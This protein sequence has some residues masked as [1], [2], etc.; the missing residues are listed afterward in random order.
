[1]IFVGSVED[2]S[3][4]LDANVKARGVADTVE[5]TGWLSEL[6]LAQLYDKA[7]ATVNPSTYEG[8]G[9]PVG[10]SLAHG[11]PTIASAIPP[12]REIAGDA[13]LYFDPGNE[14]QLAACLR[15]LVGSRELR[16]SLARRALERSRE[17]VGAGLTW[18]D[19]VV[20]AADTGDA[21]HED[22]SDEGNR[23]RGPSPRSL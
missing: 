18:R 15:S 12:H 16:A 19:V 5:S 8:Y 4:D 3:L 7:L 22:G 23:A 6:A 10:E 20:A 21:R 11:L 13:A 9:L 17:L 1:V 2:S 14:H